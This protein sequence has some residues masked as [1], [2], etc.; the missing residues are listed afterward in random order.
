MNT[1][2]KIFE[3]VQIVKCKLGDRW[4]L[5]SRDE[6]GYYHRY[7]NIQEFPLRCTEAE[8]IEDVKRYAAKYNLDAAAL[9]HIVQE[10]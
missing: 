4:M 1:R 8:V 10:D 7:M 9:L 2:E 3:G 6:N 5:A